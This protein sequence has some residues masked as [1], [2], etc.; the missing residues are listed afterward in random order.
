MEEKHASRV[1][2]DIPRWGRRPPLIDEYP[3]L[4]R[5]L[6]DG[7]LP[8]TRRLLE[9]S[10][11]IIWPDIWKISRYM[12]VHNKRCSTDRVHCHP[13]GV[14]SMLSHAHIVQYLL[15]KPQVRAHV[16]D[17]VTNLCKCFYDPVDYRAVS[18]P[19]MR[20][21]PAHW[22]ALHLTICQGEGVYQNRPPIDAT[23][24]HNDSLQIVKDLIHAKAS[25]IVSADQ[26]SQENITILHTA[27]LKGR[28]DILS[29]LLSPGFSR[30]AE[31]DI[32]ARDRKGRTPLHYA[33]LRYY[34]E[35]H[36]L[37][38]IGF[39]IA[40][41]ADLES[42]DKYSQTPFTLALS[43]GCLVSAKYLFTRHAP[44][45]GFRFLF[46]HTGT[47]NY[48]LQ[49]LARSFET[50]FVMSPWTVEAV[51]PDR[52][53]LQRQDLIR[54]ILKLSP[55]GVTSVDCGNHS[56]QDDIDSLE[57]EV[58]H[59]LAIA[60][61][62]GSNPSDLVLW[63][64]V[65]RS[66]DATARSGSRQKWT[67]ALHEA[68]TSQ[69]PSGGHRRKVMM[70]A[71][72]DGATRQ[73]VGTL[74]KPGY[75]PM[76]IETL[77]ELW[78]WTAL[79]KCLVLIGYGVGHPRL[80]TANSEGL[81]A[82]DLAIQRSESEERALRKDQDTPNVQYEYC[83]YRFV[84]HLLFNLIQPAIKD[85]ASLPALLDK[86][87]QKYL[88]AKLREVI[89]SKPQLAFEMVTAGVDLTDVKENWFE[90]H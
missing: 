56:L 13:L 65:N 20:Q 4:A 21:D 69:P 54:T 14:A 70:H 61:H 7:D 18:A 40:Q 6:Q 39:L 85:P 27:A 79:K 60:A 25:L 48:P 50:F 32:N 55:P 46:P 37:S 3:D 73:M 42:R 9:S 74:W 24:V 58:R 82:L 23:P 28:Y 64:L 45:H 76:F 67:T 80:R 30:R 75:T 16:D 26:P 8:T 15:T 44:K 11:V 31:I 34:S 47:M 84:G 89:V 22:T 36:D 33:V 57:V 5:A 10:P 17:P 87:D 68:V 83:P 77:Q 88:S 52:W 53:E 86:A 43:F 63:L 1:M 72:Y 49:V 12:P 19:N 66:A 71:D 38:G 90:I 78:Q 2:D 81:T 29:Y 41:G 59:P 51:S 35:D 62:E